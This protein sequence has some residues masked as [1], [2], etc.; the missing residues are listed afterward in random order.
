MEKMG[1]A[2][3]GPINGMSGRKQGVA[4]IGLDMTYMDKRG[5]LGWGHPDKSPVL[6]LTHCDLPFASYLISDPACKR[7]ETIY[8]LW[9]LEGRGYIG[10]YYIK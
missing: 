10:K 4:H 9:D 1:I 3:S 2:R 7:G 8:A 5:G 6:P